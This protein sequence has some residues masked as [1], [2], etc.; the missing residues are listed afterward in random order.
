MMLGLLLARAGIDVV[1][2]EKHAD[3]VRDF[4]GET[5]HSSTLELMR[6]LGLLEEFLKLPQH[7]V[8]RLGG[9]VGDERVTVL[10]KLFD[11]PPVLC[12]IPARLVGVGI[13]TEHVHAPDV[14]PGSQ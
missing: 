1:V 2:L 3:F 14:L 11:V 4:R 12:R 13:R 7:K 10:L 9:Q 6:E 5:V 8:E